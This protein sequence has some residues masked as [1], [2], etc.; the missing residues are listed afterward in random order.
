MPDALLGLVAHPLPVT[1]DVLGQT[2]R[3]WPGTTE[4]VHRAREYRRMAGERRRDLDERFVD[5]HSHWVQVGGV[6]LESEPLCLERDGPAAGER[7]EDRRWGAAA[8]LPDLRA[9][10]LEQFLVGGVL[11]HH[12][13]LNEVV[14]PGA[15]AHDVLVGGEAVRMRGGVV[16]ELGKEH[17]PTCHQGTSR[18]P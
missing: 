10:F 1:P 2:C 6:C 18:P 9:G 17:C 16:D 5:E 3:P 14:K 15:L 11:P 8:G 13:P 7:V 4:L 12:Q